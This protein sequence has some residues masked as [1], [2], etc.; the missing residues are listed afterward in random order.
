MPVTQ[1]QPRLAQPVAA[2]QQ[3]LAAQDHH[4]R[5]DVGLDL[6]DIP[7]DAGEQ[8]QAG[9]DHDQARKVRPGTSARATSRIR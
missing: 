6:P 4:R 5:E 3:Q 1:S 7:G 9:A 2:E 8:H